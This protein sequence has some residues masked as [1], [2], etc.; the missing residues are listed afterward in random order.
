MNEAQEP[1]LVPSEIERCLPAGEPL[2]GYS[3]SGV[4]D[5]N[6]N[7]A[8]KILEATCEAILVVDQE[9]E[10]KYANPQAAVLFGWERNELV[11]LSVETLIPPTYSKIH[12]THRRAYLD[13]P[14]SRRMG[15]QREML[16]RTKDGRDFYAEISL[17]PYQVGDSA[18]TICLLSDVSERV[19]T[20]QRLELSEKR[21]EQLINSFPVPTFVWQHQE[22]DFILLKYN[23]VV[24]KYNQNSL[25]GTIGRNLRS[26]VAEGS[27]LDEDIRRCYFEQKSFTSDIQSFQVPFAD[28]V[29]DLVVTYVFLEPDLVFTVIDDVTSKLAAMGELQMLS[30]AVEQTADAVLITDRNGSIKYVNPAFEGMT[31]FTRSEVL[32][33]NP[34]LLKSGKMSQEYYQQLWQTVLLGEP[35]QSQTINRRRDGSLLVVEQTITPIKDQ[36]GKII[37]LVSVLKDMTER[38]R[39][40]EKDTELRLAGQIQK[41][42]FPRQQP[43]IPGY[44]IAGAI[45]PATATSGDYFDYIEMQGNTIGIVVADVCDHGMG[46]AL[47]MAEIRAYLRLIVGYESN[48]RVIL[49]Q[50]NHQIHPDIDTHGFV[51]VFLARLDPTGNLLQCANAGNYP[52]FILNREGAFKNELR[53]DGLPLGVFTELE[54]RPSEPLVLEPGDTAIFLTDGIPEASNA[55]GEEFGVERTLDVIRRYQ[56]EAAE[57][58]VEQVRDE[59][60]QFMGLTEQTDDQTIVICKRTL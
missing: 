29:R 7:W 60:L 48:P 21:I 8:A 54:L 55:D 5:Q 43:H 51:T 31:G 1:S 16:A 24:Q 37:H 38:I 6:P 22:A 39:L 53:T 52:A 25:K 46:P 33:K 27:E 11:G 14:T 40:Q 15:A 3:V 23:T 34:R 4:L 56:S 20:N 18:L 50:I 59:V 32:G 42:L 17:S 19:L 49:H 45:F 58:I 30:S 35:F 2:N 9:G 26:I 47:F 13:N 28:E 41:Q 10:I 57:K 44:D 12:Q 36:Y